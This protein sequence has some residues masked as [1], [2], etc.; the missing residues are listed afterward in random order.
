[1]GHINRRRLPRRVARDGAKVFCFA[2]PAGTGPDLAVALLDVSAGGI[3]LVV[4][5]PVRSGHEVC[6][7][8]QGP[9]EATPRAVR[10]R[11][12]WC[13]ALADGRHAAGVKFLKPLGA[14]ALRA[15]ARPA[16]TTG[17][18]SSST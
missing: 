17:P 6:I 10:A 3:Q 18:G 14:A 15:F 7:G 1:M 9:V 2:D 12:L 16:S 4:G 8:L 5:E 11:V 13:V